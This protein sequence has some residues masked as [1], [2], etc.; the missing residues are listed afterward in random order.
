MDVL[1]FGSIEHFALPYG[2]W[3]PTLAKSDCH[4]NITELRL[5][6]LQLLLLPRIKLLFYNL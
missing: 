3:A 2:L 6:A 5:K 1:A 4:Q